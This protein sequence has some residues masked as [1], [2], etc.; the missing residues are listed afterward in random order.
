M[1]RIPAGPGGGGGSSSGSDGD[2]DS[3]SS[4][5]G[6]DGSRPTGHVGPDQTPEPA[7]GGSGGGDGG[8]GGGGGGGSGQIGDRTFPTDQVT[9]PTDGGG[10]GGGGGGSGGGGGGRQRGASPTEPDPDTRPTVD[11]PGGS[12]AGL[13]GEPVSE[14]EVFGD[15]AGS[16]E[17]TAREHFARER[18][19]EALGADPSEVTFRRRD[20]DIIAVAPREQSRSRPI[21]SSGPPP[22]AARRE[23]MGRVGAYEAAR[24]TPSADP[25]A[26]G[27][28]SESTYAT[29][30]FIEAAIATPDESV[31]LFRTEAGQ[32]TNREAIKR[33]SQVQSATQ[34]RRRLDEEEQFGDI[35]IENPLTGNRL[36]EDLAWAADG[37]S[38]FGETLASGGGDGIFL[39]TTGGAGVR[40][41]TSESGTSAGRAV[42]GTVRGGVEG[43]NVPAVALQV[44][45][46]IEY[47]VEGVEETAAGRGGEYAEDTEAAAIERLDQLE[48]QFATDPAGT[49]GLLI[50]AIG[51]SAG[52]FG[53][54]QGTRAGLATRVALQPGEE[55]VRAAGRGA[56]RLARTIDT[57]DGPPSIRVPRGDRGQ[58]KLT[59]P[60]VE[61]GG[62]DLPSDIAGTSPVPGRT[63]DDERSGLSPG[64]GRRGPQGRGIGPGNDPR[65]RQGGGTPSTGASNPEFGGI[66]SK[67]D[68]PRTILERERARIETAEPSRQLPLDF[69][70]QDPL[71][72]GR[73]LTRR[74]EV[75][76]TDSAAEAAVGLDA[77]AASE[78]DA[79]L[80]FDQLADE[81]AS[82][83]D[84]AS[85]EN[86]RLDSA[87][88]TR[89]DQ[90]VG[91]ETAQDAALNLEWAFDQDFRLDTRT[92][93]GFEQD[94]ARKVGVEFGTE[95]RRKLPPL[96]EE[97]P[98]RQDDEDLFSAWAQNDEVFES[99]FV[100]PEKLLRDSL[101]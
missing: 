86:T 25:F 82:R 34:R 52:A 50:G 69:E 49:T 95:S 90:D 100:D 3:G 78:S 36:E 85:G 18:A 91:L 98:R 2:G 54:L 45:E 87:V 56:S 29:R 46:G 4:D 72:A 30:K 19:G 53:A 32:E 70:A 9:E 21:G 17:T 71:D 6:R 93:P 48:K 65:G 80:E 63:P 97:N 15:L 37:V 39:P 57:P 24:K 89:L 67:A 7:G 20:G 55:A 1:A 22:E 84:V 74:S 33:L 64:G 76:A 61:P 23:Q 26:T 42:G 8:G 10:D 16:Y 59:G 81:A 13:L 101:S 94:P 43:L 12:T 31:D 73:T 75:T 28:P 40:V 77:A 66:G 79:I 44:K 96:E 88:D 27:P 11:R 47:A 99:G 35:A 60:S 38:E 51:T 41:D 68:Q 5:G 58:L 62:S 83:F 92:N 14:T